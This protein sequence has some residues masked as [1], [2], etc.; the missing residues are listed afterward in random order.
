MAP[1]SMFGRDDD[2]DEK[3][4]RSDEG[5][6]LLK[7]DEVAEVAERAETARRRGPDEKKYGDRPES[8]SADVRPTMR[9]P[10]A[11]S[12]SPSDFGRPRPVAV[13]GAETD[14]DDP[15]DDGA[16]EPDAYETGPAGGATYDD[17]A[18]AGSDDEGGAYDGSYETVHDGAASYDDESY[19]TG[20]YETGS[21]DR[22]ATDD[23]LTFVTAERDDLA[24]GYVD[25]DD[26]GD[27]LEPTV[28]FDAAAAFDDPELD[29][30]LSVVVDEPATV[31]SAAERVFDAELD[32]VIAPVPS[33][34]PADEPV[35]SG[36]VLS[37]GPPT[38]ETSLPHWTEPATG[39]VPRVVAGADEGVDEDDRWAAFAGSSPRWR[40][41]H[42]DWS[43]EDDTGFHDLVAAED[44]PLGALDESHRLM[45]EEYLTF[46]DLDV[47][48]A[49]PSS[50]RRGPTDPIKIQRSGGGAS[51]SR[52]EARR[53]GAPARAGSPNPSPPARA[54]TPSGRDRDQAVRV[55]V[56]IAVGAL[57]VLLLGAFTPLKFLPLLLVVPAVVGCLGE[58]FNATT[59]AGF[60]PITVVGLVV[61]VAMPLAAYFAGSPA[62]P[63]GESGIMLVLVLAVAA[64]MAWY[65]FGAG[66]GRPVAN[67]AITLAGILYVAVLGSYASLIL[68]S[69]P[70]PGLPRTTI[71][72]GIPLFIIVGVGTTM[73]DV[74]GYLLGSRV[75]KRPLSAASPNKTV[76]GLL[77]GMAGTLLT[78]LFLGAIGVGV[79]NAGQALVLGL[80]LAIVAPVG[81]LFESMIKRDLGVKD[82]SNL[83]PA[84]GGLL[85]RVDAYLFT[86]PA[87][88]YT[89]RMLGLV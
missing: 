24:P 63:A 66:K 62:V 53:P 16:D 35:P 30:D 31:R 73:Y 51:A 75:G 72:Q 46:D 89:L 15:V 84:H 19:E 39:E 86:L 82:M 77:C 38:G 21:D 18:Y 71:D 50:A 42:T 70:W 65:L 4:A 34:D 88:Y 12:A 52:T 7:S 3:P 9:F 80:V 10:L 87:G 76:E 32:D 17:S 37:V 67:I 55:G 69:G 14:R 27:E 25:A 5:V 6:R 78:V 43:R 58:F 60:R 68:R 11:G 81:D 49:A 57:V 29:D 85:D 33:D 74:A 79:R 56:G 48:D 36:P 28:T 40:D 64:S 20:S 26:A 41:E 45:D 13:P 59:R 23:G 22:T 2:G 54:A 8:P 44:A 83:I 1:N 61:G 47:P